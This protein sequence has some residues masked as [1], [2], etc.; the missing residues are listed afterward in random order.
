MPDLPKAIN[1]SSVPDSDY[2][3][4]KLS[5]YKEIS[6]PVDSAKIDVA[7]LYT[8]YDF[9]NK[10][11]YFSADEMPIKN[12]HC[13]PNPDNYGYIVNTSS[14]K[15]IVLGCKK[16]T[17]PVCGPKRKAVMYHACNAYFGKFSHIRMWTLNM[18]SSLFTNVVDHHKA[19]QECWRRLITELRRSRSFSPTQ[20]TFKFV[21]VVELHVSGF[22][23]FHVLLDTY[24]DILV[25]LPIWKRIVSEVLGTLRHSASIGMDAL[26]S[27]DIAAGYI[28]KY[29]VKACDEL[30]KAFRRW[31]KSE[32][33]SLF[34][35]SNSSKDW[36]YIPFHTQ[37]I[38][39]FPSLE[40]EISSLL[41]NR[42]V[43]SHDISEM[44]DKRQPSLYSNST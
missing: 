28:V 39:H 34:E 29:I 24:F 18:T 10:K 31:S 21:K 26:P 14:G 44:R 35:K 30:P 37:E 23:H 13:C 16:W 4:L 6:V 27:S 11:H 1:P 33:F 17:C 41:G 15:R 22:T 42:A 9:R 3:S 5:D 2:F 19:L 20:R 8:I 36:C 43:T 38:D 32:R 25:L 12:G 40:F 7:S